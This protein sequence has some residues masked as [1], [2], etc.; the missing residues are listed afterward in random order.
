[1]STSIPPVNGAAAPAG[2]CSAPIGGEADAFER[3]LAAASAP[4]G[5]ASETRR[6]APADRRERDDDSASARHSDA[7][8]PRETEEAPGAVRRHGGN[9][10]PRGDTRDDAAVP[11]LL[12]AHALVAPWAAPPIASNAAPAPPR[13]AGSG[14]ARI[15]AHLDRLL[16]DAGP[17]G[18]NGRA[19]AAFTLSG[20][21]LADTSASLTRTEGGW[22]LR[23]QS[24]DPLLLTDSRRHEAAL[25]KRFADRGLGELIVEQI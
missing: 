13:D 24:S 11:A 18:L 10:R 22:L 15:S 5:D 16:I 6:A 3:C 12:P 21:V 14:W 20:N 17:P 4:Q 9:A 2:T 8:D 23:I 7:Q 19:A 25:R 1:M